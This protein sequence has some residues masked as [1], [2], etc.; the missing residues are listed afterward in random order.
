[1]CEYYLFLYVL[2]LTFHISKEVSSINYKYVLKKN[3]K[4]I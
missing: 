3:N 1:M 2:N 4:C